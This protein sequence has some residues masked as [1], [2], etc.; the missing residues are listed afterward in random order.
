MLIFEL[1]TIP[2]KSMENTLYSGDNIVVNKLYYGS[3]I[4][5]MDFKL[6]WLNPFLPFNSKRSVNIIK[7]KWD[8]QRLL[9]FS[10][11][12]HGEVIV[13]NS[14]ATKSEFLIK[15][16]VALPSDSLQI[17]NN[18]LYINNQLINSPES[19]KSE[20][21]IYFQNLKLFKQ[22]FDSLKNAYNQL[23]GELECNFFRSLMQEKYN[24]KSSKKKA[25]NFLICNMSIVQKDMVKKLSMV[26]SICIHIDE[27]GFRSDF[28]PN[29]ENFN[30]TK[31]NLDLLVIPNK[32]M[33]MILNNRNYA[34]YNHV[35][36]YYEKVNILKTD[37][38]FYLGNKQVKSYCFM[39]D[40]YF[41]LGDNY[42]CSRDSRYF[43][44]V[45]EQY[46]VGKA[47]RILFSKEPNSKIRWTRIFK[48]IH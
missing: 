13:F 18:K 21:R 38:G 26:D 15:R 41:V 46:I 8:Y 19:S 31:S 2:S 28:L 36:K 42:S 22:Q 10:K 17:V 29:N 12:K 40:Y 3:R 20:Y 37:S 45:P 48:T 6:T 24:T 9:S 23:F 32:G 16:C 14:P 1:Y 47:T 25:V 34:L 33:E 4:L 43:G 39:Q 11:I 30:W 7:V 35:I 5:P 44:F 27:L